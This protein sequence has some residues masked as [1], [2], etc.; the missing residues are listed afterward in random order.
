MEAKHLVKAPTAKLSWSG[1]RPQGLSRGLC[2]S[3]HDT[4]HFINATSSS[5]CILCFPRTRDIKV[6]TKDLVGLPQYLGLMSSSALGL[7][8]HRPAEQIMSS[9]RGAGQWNNPYVTNNQGGIYW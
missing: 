2:V 7:C 1:S 5:T 6:V 3:N 8:E 4:Q 9:R